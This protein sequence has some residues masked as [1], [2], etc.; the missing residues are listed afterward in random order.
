MFIAHHYTFNN[1][2]TEVLEHMNMALIKPLGAGS[3]YIL[4][5]V[6]DLLAESIIK[7]DPL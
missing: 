5:Q 3:G 2:L 7:Y 6:Y 4:E 1:Q